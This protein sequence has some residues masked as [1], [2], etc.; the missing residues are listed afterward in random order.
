[1]SD[2]KELQTI[3]PADVGVLPVNVLSEPPQPPPQAIEPI[4]QYFAYAHLTPR[5]AT[6]SAQFATLA[7]FIVT[8]LPRSAERTVALR[9]LLESRDAALRAALPLR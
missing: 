7:D 5:L 1:M 6:V 3:T 9:K 2:E 8:V 4:M